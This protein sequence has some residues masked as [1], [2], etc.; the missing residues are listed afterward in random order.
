MRTLFKLILL[1]ALI[2]GGWYVWSHYDLQNWYQNCKSQPAQLRLKECFKM[3]D[4]RGETT[5]KESAVLIKDC[6]FFPAQLSITKGS[7]VTWY[8]Q[9]E[10]IHQIIDDF[11]SGI[12]GP[13]KYH[14]KTFN[15]IGSFQY[16]CDDEP[17]NKGEII[18]K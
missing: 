15:Q 8:N 2:Y 6:Q 17:A 13:G 3:P 5:K 9:D 1:G 10:I 12:I 11:E 7:K 16:N 4:K 14:S 18:V